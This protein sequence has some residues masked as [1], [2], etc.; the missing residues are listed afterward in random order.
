M[1]PKIAIITTGGTISMRY[2]AR[3]GGAVPAV[4]GE[5]LMRLVPGLDDVARV[6]LIEFANV[7]SCHLTP[8]RMF[9]LCGVIRE[10]LEREDTPEQRDSWN[11]TWAFLEWNL[12][13]YQ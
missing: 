10:T 8:D 2:D 4:S 1:L 5:E 6:E 13:P 12:R 11:R 7:P 9:E 3:L